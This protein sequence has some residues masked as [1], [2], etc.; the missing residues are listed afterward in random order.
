[1]SEPRGVDTRPRVEEEPHRL[2]R[3]YG[4]TR[5]IVDVGWTWRP[6]CDRQAVYYWIVSE[7]PKKGRGRPAHAEAA[8]ELAVPSRPTPDDGTHTA[9]EGEH[10]EATDDPSWRCPPLEHP[11]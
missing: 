1:M 4:E 6:D 3:P 2:D 7:I 8:A 11:K 9:P 10:G 5:E